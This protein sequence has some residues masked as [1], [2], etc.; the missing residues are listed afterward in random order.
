M[1]GHAGQNTVVDLESCESGGTC[2]DWNGAPVPGSSTVDSEACELGGTCFT[3]GVEVEAEVE[4]DCVHNGNDWD[5]GTSLDAYTCSCQLGWNGTHCELDIN[6][7]ASDPCVNGV[8]V[9]EIGDFNCECPPGYIGN[10]CQIAELT[11]VS[12]NT[13]LGRM[14]YAL[15]NL[16][17]ILDPEWF[18]D[19]Q[20][21]SLPGAPRP[22]SRAS[23]SGS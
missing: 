3:D 20:T 10:E 6:E 5:V 21:D 12:I 1:T 4:R 2:L 18:D 11:D 16:R 13:A 15:I 19:V 17:K 7:C 23:A 9:D 8:C 14:R 22:S